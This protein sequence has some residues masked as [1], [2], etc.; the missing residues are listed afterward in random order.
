M[1]ARQWG[2]S[3]ATEISV[4]RCLFYIAFIEKGT[5]LQLEITRSASWT[6]KWFHLQYAMTLIKWCSKGLFVNS[7]GQG[8]WR[9][10]WC[11]PQKWAAEQPGNPVPL[12][13]RSCRSTCNAPEQKT[14]LRLLVSEANV[15]LWPPHTASCRQVINMLPLLHI[16]SQSWS[17][18]HTARLMRCCNAPS[19]GIQSV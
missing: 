4:D 9:D 15:L 17:V 5:G 3:S 1:R 2:L 7:P 11:R 12:C 8:L 18:F 16:F 6:C 10:Q 14:T 19:L 13:P